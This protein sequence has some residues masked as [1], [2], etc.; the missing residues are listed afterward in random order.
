MN[1]E[2]QN[3]L[4]EKFKELELSLRSYECTTTADFFAAIAKK[5]VACKSDDALQE[6]LKEM[7][8]VSIASYADFLPEDEKR[9]YDL[10][11]FIVDNGFQYGPN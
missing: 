8:P 3:R 2:F 5:A 11:D 10:Y 6:I 7:P 4:I 9:L 1:K